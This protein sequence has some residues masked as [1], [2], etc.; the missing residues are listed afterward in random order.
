MGS[1]WATCRPSSPAKGGVA[2][3][4]VAALAAGV[5]DLADTGEVVSGLMQ[6]GA[7]HVD[8][9]ASEAFA[10]DQHLGRTVG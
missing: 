7:E 4:V 10:A 2:A 1:R 9:A 5:A 6:Q 8:R 3:V